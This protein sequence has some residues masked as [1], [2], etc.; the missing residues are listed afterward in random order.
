MAGGKRD[1]NEI[2]DALDANAREPHG[3]QVGNRY[4]RRGEP[5]GNAGRVF[6]GRI[7]KWP[8]F[9]QYPSDFLDSPLTESVPYYCD[10]GM[11]SDEK[12]DRWMASGGGGPAEM[13]NGSGA[14]YGLE[15]TRWWGWWKHRTG[16]IG[17]LNY[18]CLWAGWR[19]SYSSGRNRDGTSCTGSGGIKG[20]RGL[21]P[22]SLSY[23]L[24]SLDH[25]ARNAHA[26]RVP[27]S[28]SF[29]RASFQDGGKRVRVA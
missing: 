20:P 13:E 17:S 6:R 3:R 14:G 28:G 29:L 24:F 18:C 1:I 25:P 16:N 7:L 12:S 2:K 10:E 4:H 27:R 22:L 5:R 21:L 19:R 9:R 15:L 8:L 26:R 11:A 23:A